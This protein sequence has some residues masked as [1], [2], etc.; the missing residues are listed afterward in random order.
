M[1][2]IVHAPRASVSSPLPVVSL[3][4][5]PRGPALRSFCA[6]QLQWHYQAVQGQIHSS[7]QHFKVLYT[8]IN[9][10]VPALACQMSPLMRV[11]DTGK[12]YPSPQI[13]EASTAH[14]L[15]PRPLHLRTFCLLRILSMG[16]QGGGG[17]QTR[18]G[19]AGGGGRCRTRGGT[20]GLRQ[21]GYGRYWTPSA[22]KNG[23]S[24]T[25]EAQV[26]H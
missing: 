1:G 6:K 21:G 5:G 19:C 7:Y 14:A 9:P 24:V 20:P 15:A 12:V 16:W 17:S 22:K 13:F 10:V 18:P 3:A 25:P 2:A 23:S 11:G 8:S 4:A 26:G